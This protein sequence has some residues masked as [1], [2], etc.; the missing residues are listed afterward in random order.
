MAVSEGVTGVSATVST[1]PT[2]AFPSSAGGMGLGRKVLNRRNNAVQAM[3]NTSSRFCRSTEGGRA[4]A[5]GWG[6]V[7]GARAGH[8]G[9][10]SHALA[11]IHAF[12][13]AGNSVSPPDS[14]K[15]EVLRGCGRGGLPTMLRRSGFRDTASYP[16][17]RWLIAILRLSL[18]TDSHRPRLWEGVCP[19]PLIRQP[20]IDVQT[21]PDR[22]GQ[23]TLE[24]RRTR[25]EVVRTDV[26][27]G[28]R[29]VDRRGGLLDVH[30]ARR[31]GQRRTTGTADEPEQKE[32]VELHASRLRSFRRRRQP[33]LFLGGAR[34]EVSDGQSERID[35]F[36]AGGQVPNAFG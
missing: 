22:F 6:R 35:R 19:L 29:V 24:V 11:R 5:G 2:S 9:Q 34:L 18:F 14:A 28:E 21:V 23:G 12:G 27:Q 25:S 7:R 30:R 20:R 1:S 13:A 3:K 31:G 36:A 26:G 16:R 32:G 17:S 10:E 33:R 8:R 4:A 15:G